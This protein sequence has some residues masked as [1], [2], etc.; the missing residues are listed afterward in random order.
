[1]P[2]CSKCDMEFIDGI[3]VCSDCGG[4]LMDT[5]EV[6]QMLENKKLLEEE[7]QLFYDTEQLCEDEK[8]ET[9]TRPETK[10]YITKRQ[11][12]EDM[13][14]SIS[15]FFM[16]GCIFFVFGILCIFKIITLPLAS[17][18]MMMF[19]VVLTAMGITCLTVAAVTKKSA[20]EMLRD[21]DLEDICTKE[22]IDWFRSTYSSSQLDKHLLEEDSSLEEHDI[23]LKRFELIQDYLITAHDLPNPG[24]VDYLCEEIYGQLFED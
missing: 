18:P 6:L 4:P 15:A 19:Q 3:T 9:V 5:A 24:Y 20:A 12:Y 21:A 16:L 22:L 7:Q 23:Y 11:R 1:M 8:K 17:G 2:Y 10:A 14:A 13:K